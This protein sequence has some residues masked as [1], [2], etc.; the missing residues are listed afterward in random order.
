MGIREGSCPSCACLGTC[1]PGHLPS[2]VPAHVGTCPAGYLPAWI[3]VHV[4]TCPS[5]SAWAPAYLGTCPPGHLPGSQTLYSRGTLP[6]LLTVHRGQ[7]LP[8]LWQLSAPHQLPAGPTQVSLVLCTHAYTPQHRDPGLPW[9]QGL[10]GMSAV[11]LAVAVLSPEAQPLPDTIA[12]D[13]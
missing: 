2:W 6:S 10:C 5:V 4:G 11:W 7:M 8:S 3:P 12:Q 1:L 9:P 13:T